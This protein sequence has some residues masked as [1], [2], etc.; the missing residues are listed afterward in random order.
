LT[1]RRVRTSMLNAD[2]DQ[3]TLKADS[4]M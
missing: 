3:I 1:V 4:F 2:I